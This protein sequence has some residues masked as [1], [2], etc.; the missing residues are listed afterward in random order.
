MGAGPVNLALR[1]EVQALTAAAQAAVDA[2]GPPESFNAPVS[3][4][5]D[6]SPSALVLICSGTE[7]PIK[8]SVSPGSGISMLTPL[9]RSWAVLALANVSW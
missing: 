9:R 6:G 1:L 4:E 5:V 2:T 8:A 3:V 7:V